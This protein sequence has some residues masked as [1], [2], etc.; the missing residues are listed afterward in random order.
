MLPEGFS[1]GLECPAFVGVGEESVE[2]DFFEAGGED[3]QGEAAEEFDGGEG[4][5]VGFV[6]LAV[7]GGEGDFSVGYF[8]NAVVG[9]G[10]AVGVATEVFEYL[11]GT[12]EGAFGVDVPTFF[13]FGG[14]EEAVEGGGIGEGFEFAV[15]L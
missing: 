1:D 8:L 2:S 12:A 11:G 10:D 7:F 13:L 3:V 5:G 4:D 14:V 15:E 6:F 9:E